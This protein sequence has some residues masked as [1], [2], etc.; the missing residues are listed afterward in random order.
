MTAGRRQQKQ[1]QETGVGGATNPSVHSTERSDRRRAERSRTKGAQDRSQERSKFSDEKLLGIFRVPRAPDAR[2][3]VPPRVTRAKGEGWKYRCRYNKNMWTAK[4]KTTEGRQKKKKHGEQNTT[5]IRQYPRQHSCWCNRRFPTTA[6]PPHFSHGR[7][8]KAPP[9]TPSA[10]KDDNN[11]GKKCTN[12]L[13]H[14][15]HP[16]PNRRLEHELRRLQRKAKAGG[17]LVELGT[18]VGGDHAG[19]AHRLGHGLLERSGAELEKTRGIRVRIL[20]AV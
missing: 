18:Q 19:G 17:E 8:D 13:H 10:N 1:R 14:R 7:P 5:P 6:L 3:K 15:T 20:D 12:L 2:P 11:R 9:P 4:N 16:L